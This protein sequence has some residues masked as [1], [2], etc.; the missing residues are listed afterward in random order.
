MTKCPSSNPVQDSKVSRSKTCSLATV[1]ITKR[2]SQDFRSIDSKSSGPR[3]KFNSGFQSK[4]NLSKTD[5]INESLKR[6]NSDNRLSRRE[7]KI[8]N[9]TQHDSQNHMHK[10]KKTLSQKEKSDTEDLPPLDFIPDQNRT[11]IDKLDSFFNQTEKI[12]DVQ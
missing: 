5:E 9:I 7:L 3:S 1:Q 4:I 2:N 11:Q 10:L 8:G 6:E 12:D